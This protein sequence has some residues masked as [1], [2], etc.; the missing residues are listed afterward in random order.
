MPIPRLAVA[1]TML[2]CLTGL[3]N[4]S[5]YKMIPAVFHAESLS[6][7]VRTANQDRRLASALVGLAG[8]IG[9]FGGVFVQLAFR[10]SFLRNGDADVAYLAFIGFY[11]VCAAVTW[12]VYVRPRSGQLQGV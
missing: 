12:T 6:G 10:E 2:F 3:G 8:A 4:G 7:G 1:F 5:V 11:L 9:A